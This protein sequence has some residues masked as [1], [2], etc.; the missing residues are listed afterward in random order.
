MKFKNK[1]GVT[2]YLASKCKVKNNYTVEFFDE[3]EAGYIDDAKTLET[4]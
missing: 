1:I 4:L 2:E 3:S